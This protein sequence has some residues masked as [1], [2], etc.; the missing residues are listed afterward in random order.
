MRGWWCTGKERTGDVHSPGPGQEGPEQGEMFPEKLKQGQTGALMGMWLPRKMAGREARVGALWLMGTVSRNPQAIAGGS[1]VLNLAHICVRHP[2]CTRSE[3]SC[4]VEGKGEAL[5]YGRSG[6]W[7][8]WQ[9]EELGSGAM[10]HQRAVAATVGYQGG[11]RKA[12]LEK[13]LR[14]QSLKETAWN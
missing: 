7:S 13:R 11:N 9:Q 8:L 10:V 12:A 2:H 6:G 4:C 14:V 5:E 1:A 3:R